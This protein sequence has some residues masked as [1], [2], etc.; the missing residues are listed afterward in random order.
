MWIPRVHRQHPIT[1]VGCTRGRRAR[2]I[3]AN[4][5]IVQ[6]PRRDRT[7]PPRSRGRVG[8]RLAGHVLA[9]S[10][11]LSAGGAALASAGG[12]SIQATEGALFSGQ[13]AA[14]TCPGGPRRLDLFRAALRFAQR[15]LR[16]IAGSW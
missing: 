7:W 9:V 10:L 2:R 4:T 1:N 15:G 14:A 11:C 13:V 6:R 5:A 16:R 12:S 3:I 8:G